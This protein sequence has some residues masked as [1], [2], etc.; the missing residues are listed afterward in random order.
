MPATLESN[1]AP[2]TSAAGLSP[3]QK[4]AVLLI[5]LGTE[6]AAQLLK[7]FDE[8]EIEVVSAEMAKCS[9]VTQELQRDVLRDFSS[10]VVEATTALR[11]GADFAQG[12]LEKGLGRP[13]AANILNR[14]VPSRTPSPAL[15]QLSELEPSQVINVLK[16]ERPQTLALVTSCLPSAKASQ[17]LAQLETGLREQVVERLATLGPTPVEAVERV[18]EVLLQKAGS[19]QINVLSHTGG[20]KAAATVLNGID[21]RLS[22][23]LLTSLEERNPELGLAI[24]QKMFTFE[25]LAR[26]Q[27][28]HLQRLLREVD[29]RDLAMALK[30]TSEKLKNMLLGCISKRAAETVKEE[31]SFLGAIKLR[32]IEAAQ[33]RI[34]DVLRRLESDGEIDLGDGEDKSNA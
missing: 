33:L 10:T 17:V 30:R 27:T 34:V 4:L 31:I 8:A 11:G 5:M 21:K 24:R 19:R 3:Q 28:V 20:V 32:D 15:Q 23:T 26:L 2:I 1:P 22:Q 13:K 9:V 18:V 25:D 14:V 6:S 7:N 16:N 12:V 29:L